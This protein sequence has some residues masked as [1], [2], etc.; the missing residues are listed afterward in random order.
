[1]L[2]VMVA[3]WEDLK[4]SLMLVCF[5]PCLV[6]REARLDMICSCLGGWVVLEIWQLAFT[7]TLLRLGDL[8]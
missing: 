8:W 3:E 7:K 1:M 6:D 5:S 4:K 2:S